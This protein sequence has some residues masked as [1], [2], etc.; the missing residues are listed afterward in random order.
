M[1]FVI[2]L[3]IGLILLFTLVLIIT[4]RVHKT[5]A[6]M[7]GAGLTIIVATLPGSGE[8]GSFL[9]PDIEHA[10]QL[11]EIDLILVIIGITLMVGVARTTGLFDFIT[12]VILKK[13]GNNQ[14]KLLAALSFLTLIFSALLD[15][16]MAII[17][18][19]SIT[20][21]ACD[22]L[23]I[24]PKPFILAEAIF[25]DLGGIITRIASPPNLILGGHFDIDFITF[26]LLTSPFAFC[27]S[28]LTLV[29]WSII[30]RKDLT[31]PISSSQYHEILLINERAVI[32]DPKSFQNA[33][34]ILIGTIL[35][36]IITPF[37]PMKIELGY[38]SLAGGFLMVGL[39]KTD[40]HEALSTIEWE[41]VFFLIGLLTVIGIAEKVGILEI[42]VEPLNYIF[43]LNTLGGILFLQWI[44]ALASAILDNIPVAT[45]MT[46]VM[47]SLI[48]EYPLELPFVPFLLSVVIGTNLGGNITPIG[49][50]STVQAIS[51][52]DRVEREDA[53]TTFI[54]FVKIGGSV[55]FFQL[56]LGSLYIILMW[57]IFSPL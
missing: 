47:D 40:F 21:V 12:L 16:Y 52:L 19:S 43:S 13:S 23:D 5:L 42:I 11:I 10:I 36:F 14:F 49:S 20:I 6:A 26:F 45:I 7:I 15:A 8:N 31:K 28:F 25:G 2:Q 4:E 48:E 32:T 41:I 56:L 38:I 24:N 50:A 35:A 18:V 39:V 30:F 1:S 55:A 34:I 22:A 44:T 46:S 37:L 3:I 51:F 57:I 54:E 9:I 29:I 17:I 53:K 27:A 33:A